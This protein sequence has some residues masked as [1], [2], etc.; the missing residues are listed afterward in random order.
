MSKMSVES[1][2]VTTWRNADGAL[3]RLDGPAAV[4]PTGYTAWWLDGLRHRLD[5]PAV[6]REDD[7]YNSWYVSG[8][9]HRL[10][11]PAIEECNGD[12]LWYIT[13]IRYTNFKDFQKAGNLSD[14]DMM[15]LRLKY[16]EIT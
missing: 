1:D 14:Q 3:H 7:G 13:G 4:G 5:G 6:T 2:G 10:D 11:G 8:L 16:G 12:K 15:V 9:R